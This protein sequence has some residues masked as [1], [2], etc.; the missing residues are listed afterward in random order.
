MANIEKLRMDLAKAETAQDE[1]VEMALGITH[2]LTS[3]EEIGDSVGL[4]MRR[5]AWAA[6]ALDKLLKESQDNWTRA[7]ALRKKI[8]EATK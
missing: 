7:H 6:M 4:S 2:L 5:I 1:A 3:V 8:R